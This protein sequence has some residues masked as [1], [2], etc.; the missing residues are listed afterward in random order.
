M[1]GCSDAIVAAV[2]REVEQRRS[3]LDAASDLGEVTIRVRLQAGTSWVKGVVWEEERVYRRVG[4]TMKEASD[5]I[6]T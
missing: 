4:P 1:T 6:R 3:L 2:R 5:S